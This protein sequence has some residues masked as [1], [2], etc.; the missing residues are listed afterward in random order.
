MDPAK[1]LVFLLLMVAYERA[2][3]LM[4]SGIRRA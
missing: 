4:V 1:K 2:A 3:H